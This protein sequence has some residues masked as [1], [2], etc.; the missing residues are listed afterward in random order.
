MQEETTMSFM[1]FLV[2]ALIISV[3]YGFAMASVASASAWFMTL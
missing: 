3:I 1:L 2:P